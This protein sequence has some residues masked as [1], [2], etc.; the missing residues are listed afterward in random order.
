MRPKPKPRAKTRTW[1]LLLPVIP[2][3]GTL[4]LLGAGFGAGP[5]TTS[6]HEHVSHAVSERCP[7]VSL[8]KSTGQTL[9]ARREPA[10]LDAPGAKRAEASSDT[11]PLRSL[12]GALRQAHEGD[13]PAA[14][15]A[16]KARVRDLVRKDPAGA[17]RELLGAIRASED[18]AQLGL[19]LGLLTS[20]PALPRDEVRAALLDMAQHDDVAMRRAAALHGLGQVRSPD[21]A[22][23]ADVA[24]CAH[25]DPDPQVRE[26]AATALGS[27]GDRS[28]GPLAA[29][30][31]RAIVA[32]LAD[33]REGRVRATLVYAVRDTREQPVSDALVGALGDS[34]PQ[35]RLAAADML[36]DVAAAHR[37]DAV[38]AMARAFGRET[39]RDVRLCLVTAIVRAGRMNALSALEGLSGGDLQPTIDDYLAGLRSGEDNPEKLFAIR[40]ARERA[41]KGS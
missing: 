19:V 23:V 8:E 31:A 25:G 30:A 6:P 16:A 3:G 20:D 1:I 15:S 22:Q 32:D 37:A 2:A 18:E 38:S 21:E 33:E 39:Q 12:L 28:P 36:G 17:L 41:R 10:R 11:T 13:D 14:V 9:T 34:D 24:A 7:V 27:L 40:Q 4:L 29:S 35:V 26:A 5:A